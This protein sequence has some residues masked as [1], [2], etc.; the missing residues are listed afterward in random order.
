MIAKEIAR[1]VAT[2]LFPQLWENNRF[3]AIA[4][5]VEYLHEAASGMDTNSHNSAQEATTAVP[6]CGAVRA[7]REHMLKHKMH[8][9][10]VARSIGVSTYTVRTWLEGKYKPNEENSGKITNFLESLQATPELLT[11]EP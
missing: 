1:K 10:V 4:K 6:I 5:A 8:V 3:E 9:N 11:P 2:I 7:L